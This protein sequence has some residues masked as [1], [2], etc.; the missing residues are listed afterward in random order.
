VSGVDDFGHLPNAPG[1]ARYMAKRRSDGTWCVWD[2]RA[3]AVVDVRGDT[4]ERQCRIL[5]GA[6]NRVERALELGTVER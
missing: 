5:A 4:S 2:Y 1:F 6:Y 3:G